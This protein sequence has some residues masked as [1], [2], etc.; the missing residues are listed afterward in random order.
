[1]KKTIWAILAMIFFGCF[2]TATATA[3]SVD[4]I[5]EKANIASYYAGPDGTADVNMVITDAQGRER[6]R[7]F[8]I[9]RMTQEQ[10][11]PQKFY[12]YFFEPADVAN[13][14]FMVWKN[15]GADDDRW[16]YLPA[17]DLVRRIAASDKRSS[18]VGSHFV[19][20]DVSGRGIVAD[21][22]ELVETADQYYKIKST[23]KE[24]K[25]VEFK[26]YFLWVDKSNFIPVKAE[27]YNK[28]D[29]LIRTVE[30]LK[31]EMIDD[32]PTVT[33]SVATDLERGGK[34]T[35]N[36]SNVRYDIGLTE[37]I[38]TERYLRQ[39]PTEWIK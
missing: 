20:E 14:V 30:A 7:K 33:Q 3:L 36:F 25:G 21:T 6:T 39:A 37:D 35:M 11:G 23:P 16:L 28:A 29:Q 15:V 24:E 19:Y 9:L 27:Y 22:H 12:V 34:T 8:R 26:Y 38:F 31:V 17:L 13:M 1:M 18:F 4:E 32:Y 2:Q 5:V 10:G